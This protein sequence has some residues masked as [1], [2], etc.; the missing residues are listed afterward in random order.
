MRATEPG[1]TRLISS[2]SS[3]PDLSHAWKAPIGPDALL[4][5]GGGAPVTAETHSAASSTAPILCTSVAWAELR[6][7]TCPGWLV[8]VRAHSSV[9]SF[10]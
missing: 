2:H 7:P 6:I 9:G 8:P 4:R 1:V 3:S 10:Q 5:S